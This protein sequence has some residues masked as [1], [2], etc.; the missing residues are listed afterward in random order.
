MRVI[1]FE[2]RNA[3]GWHHSQRPQG[4]GE[5]YG[6]RQA[7]RSTCLLPPPHARRCR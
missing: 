7:T 5:L 6:D 2:G 4:K 1:K 3:R